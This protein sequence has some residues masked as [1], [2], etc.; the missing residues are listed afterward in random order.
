MIGKV[1]NSWDD[2]FVEVDF[3]PVVE[4]HQLGHR[5]FDFHYN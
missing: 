5:G 4:L 3:D 1:D 2:L